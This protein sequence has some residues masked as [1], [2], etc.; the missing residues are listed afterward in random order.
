M[1]SPVFSALNQHLISAGLGLPVVHENSDPPKKP[2]AWLS[3]FF[4]PADTSGASLGDT[5][6]DQTV[7]FY[8]VDISTP[9]G[10]GWAG[11]H[12][13]ADRLQRHF[14]LGTLL[15]FEGQSMQVTGSSRSPGRV[16]GGWYRLSLSIQWLAYTRR[17]GL[18]GDFCHPSTSLDETVNNLLPNAFD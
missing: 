4:L 14:R 10:N 16:E 15:T 6:L 11:L 8:Q 17:D 5:G 13:Y 2:R 9:T 1:L 3:A 12:G 18:P 7:G